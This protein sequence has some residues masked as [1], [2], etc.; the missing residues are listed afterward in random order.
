MIKVYTSG[1]FFEDQENPVEW[2]EHV[3]KE[4]P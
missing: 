4:N 1:T 3:L 2:Q